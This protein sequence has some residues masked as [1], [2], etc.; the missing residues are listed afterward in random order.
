MREL[1]VLPADRPKYLGEKEETLTCRECNS[2]WTR[3]SRRGRKPPLCPSCVEA[4]NEAK[5]I[6]APV[7]QEVLEDR[8]ALARERKAEVKRERAQRESEQQQQQ[9]QA[10][11]DQLPAMSD[12]WNR[13][14]TIAMQEN[15]PEA[16]NKCEVLMSSYVNARACGVVIP[17]S[18]GSPYGCSTTIAG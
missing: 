14:F 13:S 3:I 4:K 1:A 16:W 7:S 5:P 8:L 11:L 12:M 15:T 2:T 9:R 17:A 6:S 10:I 18:C